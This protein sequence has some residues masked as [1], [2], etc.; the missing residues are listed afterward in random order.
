MDQKRK[1]IVW[2]W[3]SAICFFMVG[4]SFVLM[5]LGGAAVY[6]SFELVAGIMFWL[7]LFG[8]IA[9][10]IVLSRH[11]KKHMAGEERS[12]NKRIGAISFFQNIPAA[13]ADLVCILSGIGLVL[14][15][16][17]MNTNSFI[18][19]VL[20]GIFTFSLSMHCILNG[21]IFISLTEPRCF[22]QIKHLGGKRE[23]QGE[24]EQ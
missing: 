1:D 16:D 5:P 12:C 18:C 19:Y 11:W 22:C 21:K 24:C 15:L 2:L 10:Q 3:I 9:A 13:I 6:S 23:K 20:L 4:A 17:L 7:F 8:G 14:M